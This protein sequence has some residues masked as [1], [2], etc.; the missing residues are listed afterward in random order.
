MFS[1][2][3]DAMRR[4]L[5]RDAIHCRGRSGFAARMRSVAMLLTAAVAT[6]CGNGGSGT[7]TT[8]PAP[9]PTPPAQAT[10]DPPPPT[11]LHVSGRGDTWIEWSWTSPFDGAGGYDVQFSM[12]EAFTEA[13]EIIPR[14]AEQLS[15]RRD[16]LPAET[17]A[18]LRVRSVTGAG[19]DRRAGAWSAQVAGMTLRVGP[20]P[21]GGKATEFRAGDRIPDFPGGLPRYTAQGSSDLAG[22]VVVIT[23]GRE[24]YAQYP[25]WIFTCEAERC[26][27]RDGVVTEGVIV[28]TPREHSPA[29]RNCS[30]ED[31]G[32]LRGAPLVRTG[33][34][35]PDCVS[36]DFPEAPT[37]Y[38]SFRVPAGLEA[39][40][41]MESS[42]FPPRLSLREGVGI[43]G[44]VLAGSVTDGETEHAARIT[45]TLSPGTYTLEA[46]SEGGSDLT[47]DFTITVAR[48]AER[49]ST[50]DGRIVAYATF[51]CRE[52]GDLDFAFLAVLDSDPT[53][54]TRERF[55]A[56]FVQGECAMFLAGDRLEWDGEEQRLPVLS[57]FL[58]TTTTA[59]RVR[60]AAG[61]VDDVDDIDALLRNES[62]LGSLRRTPPARWWTPRLGTSFISVLD[63][64]EAV[65]FGLARPGEAPAAQGGPSR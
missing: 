23:L 64:A 8:L 5:H 42:D 48:R 57:D 26:G 20:P 38:F 39:Q 60:G 28:R 33:T 22:G 59:I 54:A 45:G 61:V 19:A 21:T 27:I 31:L 6:G 1:V 34:L 13:D 11:D 46:T 12:N 30:V 16:G 56:L 14:P 50:G 25:N 10:P 7:P 41:D 62:G 52:A 58:R 3:K 63:T 17:S 2:R 43:A 49:P 37:R 40:I 24:G 9:V 32:T 44:R 36:H 29:A 18:Y 55:V 15:Y 35:G 47:G 51:A 4:F 53:P 65:G